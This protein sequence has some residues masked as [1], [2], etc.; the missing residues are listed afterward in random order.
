[1]KPIVVGFPRT[2]FTLLISIITEILLL[3]NF[4]FK[5][6]DIYLKSKINI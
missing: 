2:G 5:K 3:K 4:K 6:E 1:M